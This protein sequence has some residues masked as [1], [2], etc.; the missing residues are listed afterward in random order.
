MLP[1]HW[2]PIQGFDH[3]RFCNCS[4]L[5]FCNWRPVVIHVLMGYLAIFW[6]PQKI[7]SNIG[8][9]ILGLGHSGFSVKV[10]CFIKIQGM[11]FCL[12]KCLLGWILS[13][14]LKHAS[15]WVTQMSTAFL[16][17]ISEENFPNVTLLDNVVCLYAH[18][19][20]EERPLQTWWL[21]SSYLRNTSAYHHHH[22]T[23]CLY[24]SFTVKPLYKW[25]LVKLLKLS[26]SP[27][28]SFWKSSRQIEGGW[29]DS[30]DW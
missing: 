23:T 6:K 17:C 18:K 20:T 8:W 21:Y 9:W 28:W 1:S 16:N 29:K 26:A 15:E 25:M 2:A 30:Q 4:R 27:F 10:Y 11:E 5:R 7:E 12:K 3:F 13:Q 24:K 14:N 19:E 22:S